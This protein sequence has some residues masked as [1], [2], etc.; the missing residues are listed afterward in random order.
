ML[1]SPIYYSAILAERDA[2]LLNGSIRVK[3]KPGGKSRFYSELS[4]QSQFLFFRTSMRS[5]HILSLKKLAF[6][7]I[8]A[9]VHIR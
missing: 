6:L 3:E 2:V 1:A 7:F 5:M 4:P 8:S 9:H